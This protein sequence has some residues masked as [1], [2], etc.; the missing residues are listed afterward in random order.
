VSRYE[1]K[2]LARGAVG[3]VSEFPWPQPC[4]GLPGAWVEADAPLRLCASGVHVCRASELAHWLHEELWL[5]E[6]D[7]ERIEAMD[8][9]LATRG[10]LVQQVEAWAKGGADRFARA[11]RDHAA[12][13]VAA[14]PEADQL[15]LQQLL[16]DAAAHLPHGATALSAFC[17]AMTVAWLRGGD[18]FDDAGYREE[19]LWQSAFISRDLALSAIAAPSA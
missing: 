19:R 4:Q 3:P 18:H 17:S 5:I 2:F 1:F 15:R 11:A 9:V 7:G 16:K 10:R 12:E 6:I 8:C 13:L 14:N